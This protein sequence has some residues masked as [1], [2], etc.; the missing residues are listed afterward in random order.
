MFLW[1]VLLVFSEYG[2]RRLP[3]LELYVALF[4]GEVARTRIQSVWLDSADFGGG[5]ILDAVEKGN[6]L[7]IL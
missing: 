7:F 1:V 6:C 4:C 2:A 3:G 5:G